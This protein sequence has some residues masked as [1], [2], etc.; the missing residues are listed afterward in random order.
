MLC[1]DL[2]YFGS[3]PRSSFQSSLFI[4]IAYYQVFY[5]SKQQFHEDGL[6]ASPSAKQPAK[7]SGEQNDEENESHHSETEYEKILRPEYF[8]KQNEFCFRNI[9]LKQRPAV[10]LDKGQTKKK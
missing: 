7:R 3:R 10:Y 2:R 6:R 1:G 4:C 8:P 9:K 5:F